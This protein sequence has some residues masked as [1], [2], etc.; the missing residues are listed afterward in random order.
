MADTK[1]NGASPGPDRTGTGPDMV[2]QFLET[3][4]DGLAAMLRPWATA[5]LFVLASIAVILTMI[6]AMLAAIVIKP[7]FGRTLG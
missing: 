6:A 4:R 3:A 2:D 1:K 7:Q 5:L